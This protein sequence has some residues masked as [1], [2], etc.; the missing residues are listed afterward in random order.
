L[1]DI[2]EAISVASTVE[3][4]VYVER[5]SDEL[6]GWRWSLQHRGGTYPLLR[7][8]ARFLKADYGKI[9]ILCAARGGASYLV[10]PDDPHRAIKWRFVDLDGPMSPELVEIKILEAF[11]SGPT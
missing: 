7:I 2:A 10:Q 5:V 3:R 11:G 6:E 9:V 4:R 1:E 8:T